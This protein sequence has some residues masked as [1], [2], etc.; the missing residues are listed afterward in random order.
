MVDPIP[1]VKQVIVR[2]SP[3]VFKCGHLFQRG[4]LPIYVTDGFGSPFSPYSIKYTLFYSYCNRLIAVFPCNRIPV[5]GDIGE[6]Y[7]TGYA[8][9]GGQPGQWYIE[10]VLQEY[11]DGP[12]QGDRFGFEVFSPAEFQQNPCRP[13]GYQ[14]GERAW[15]ERQWGPGYHCC[16]GRR[17]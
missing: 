10:W 5:Q 15:L 13:N 11:F 8:G 2:S 4:D 7:A 16:G 17:F 1:L 9:E 6:Y 14:N 12:L 3:G